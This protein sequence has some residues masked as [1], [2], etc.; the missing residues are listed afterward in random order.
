MDRCNGGNKLGAWVGT[1][2]RSRLPKRR[3]PNQVCFPHTTCPPA[4]AA[5]AAACMRSAGPSP[6]IHTTALAKA[7]PAPPPA[8]P[9][10]APTSTHPAWTGS[11]TST[12][13]L[14]AHRLSLS[15]LSDTS[16]LPSC[17]T[18]GPHAA[19]AWRV[20]LQPRRSAKLAMAMVQQASSS[21]PTKRHYDG[22][23]AGAASAA[24]GLWGA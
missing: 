16:S 14:P 21:R 4:D 23:A 24:T 1:S 5:A 15:L 7:S 6:P 22:R 10:P 2:H 8:R 3:S 11:V 13:Q 17:C 20:T 19:A 9:T 12:R 18:T